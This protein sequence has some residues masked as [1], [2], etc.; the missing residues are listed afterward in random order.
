MQDYLKLAQIIKNYFINAKDWV[1]LRELIHFLKCPPISKNNLLMA[2]PYLEAVED[3]DELPYVRIILKDGHSIYYP[4]DV[5]LD[6]FYM[7]VYQIYYSNHWHYYEVDGME[8][9]KDDVVIDCGA[10]EGLFTVL[11]ADRCNKVYSIEPSPIWY[12]SL[13]MTLSPYR[14]VEIKKYALSNKSGITYISNNAIGASISNLNLDDNSFCVNVRTLDE[15]F[16]NKDS[17]PI[18]YIKADLEGSDFNMLCGAMETIYRFSPRLAIT[19]YHDKNHAIEMT[20]LIKKINP[21]YKIQ[22]RGV[23]LKNCPVMLYAKI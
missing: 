2:T 11:A 13:K 14:N 9:Q 8:I 16:L 5:N 21:K 19:T 18:S 6:M 7:V 20:K 3:K 15:E 23:A 12:K 1:T 17:N 22:W 4:K 10:A